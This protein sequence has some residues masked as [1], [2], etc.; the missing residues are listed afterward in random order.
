M[1]PR[2]RFTYTKKW[3]G[4]GLDELVNDCI[5]PYPLFPVFFLKSSFKHFPNL[6]VKLSVE[7][8]FAC[9]L[10]FVKNVEM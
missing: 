2:M 10:V 6:F 8:R 4:V 5:Q 1:V 9:Y 7:V 3:N